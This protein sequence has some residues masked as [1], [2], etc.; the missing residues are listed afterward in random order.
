MGGQMTKQNKKADENEPEGDDV[1]G[2]ATID[3]ANPVGLDVVFA[4]P[5]SGSKKKAAAVGP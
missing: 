5:A 3:Y 1:E 4:S 2:D